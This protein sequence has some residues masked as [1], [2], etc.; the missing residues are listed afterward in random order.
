MPLLIA[1][2]KTPLAATRRPTVLETR[3]VTGAGGGP[4]KTILNT[5]RFLDP[6]G[7]RTLCAFFRPPQDPGFDAIQSR[8]DAAGATLVPLDDRG[9]LDWR[10]VRNLVKLCRRENVALWHGHDYKSNLLGLLVRRF[11]PMRLITTVHGWVLNTLKSSLY[12]RVDRWCLPRYDEVICVSPDLFDQCL[13]AGVS[14]SRCHL[15]ENGIDL[16]QYGRR[17]TLQE[18]RAELRLPAAPF[19]IAAVGRLSPEK[20][21]PLLVAAVSRLLHQGRDVALAIAG[22]GPEQAALQTQIDRTPF[23]DRFRLLGF[24]S[25]PRILYEA[26]DLVALSSDREGLPNVL[27]EAMALGVPVVST[28]VAGVPR[29][30]ESESNG[31]LVPLRDEPALADAIARLHDDPS[32]RNRFA[33]NGRIT[34]QTRYSFDARIE[35]VARLYQT[36]VPAAEEKGQG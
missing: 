12:F 21:F 33:A 16:A 30:I 28:C 29:L 1:P 13:G 8:A 2:T 5:P 23:R 24:Q 20:N 3:V 34:I 9:P 11:H 27:L 6:Y 22:D 4:D 35:K 7:Y 26:S 10:L 25:D 17:R 19:L 14:P 32:L 31:L 18:A 36:L 15:I